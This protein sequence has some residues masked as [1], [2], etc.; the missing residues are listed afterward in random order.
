MSSV[1]SVAS[2]LGF[3]T[4]LRHEAARLRRWTELMQEANLELFSGGERGGAL[5]L[6]PVVAKAVIVLL[7][8]AAQLERLLVEAGVVSGEP[9]TRLAYAS[10]TAA[11]SWL[12]RELPEAR[13][14]R[15][16]IDGFVS[17]LKDTVAMN[18]AE[19]AVLAATTIDMTSSDVLVAVENLSEMNNCLLVFT[20]AL[21][22]RA[23]TVNEPK[24]P[25]RKGNP[26]T[27][28]QM[29]IHPDL[30]AQDRTRAHHRRS[31]T[32]SSDTYLNKPDYPQPDAEKK[33]LM[34]D[35]KILSTSSVTYIAEPPKKNRKTRASR[36]KAVLIGAGQCGKTSVISRFTVQKFS[37][38]YVPTTFADHLA[39]AGS[40]QGIEMTIIDTAG[41]D[42]Y[43]RL[44]PLSYP[45]ANVIAICF[46]LGCRRSLSEIRDKVSYPKLHHT[47]TSIY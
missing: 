24:R 30:P 23:T 45:E 46:S 22:M 36:A 33:A 2:S 14:M 41:Q 25:K 31:R 16:C 35:I 11:Y 13:D 1:A 44:R 34:T 40:Q 10:D 18:D 21:T 42:Q 5:F 12:V 43:D 28:Q 15:R 29:A 20:T 26:I 8:M 37:P 38:I 17:I 27:H 19:A 7:G 6:E 9:P 32:G 47:C 4:G 3:V 39:N